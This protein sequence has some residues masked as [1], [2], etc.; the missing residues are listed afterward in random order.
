[1]S[2]DDALSVASDPFNQPGT[3]SEFHAIRVE[4]T[5]WIRP[6]VTSNNNQVIFTYVSNNNDVHN[7]VWL[8]VHGREEV[9]QIAARKILGTVADERMPAAD[10]E[11]KQL[12][13]K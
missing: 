9:C 10:N 13:G 3:F 6:G 7:I 12:E 4:N 11:I 1:M 2:I 5:Y 8:P